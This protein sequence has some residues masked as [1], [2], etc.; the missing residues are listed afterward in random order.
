MI[1]GTLQ[2]NGVECSFEMNS[3]AKWGDGVSVHWLEDVVGY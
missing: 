3:G 2:D 1:H